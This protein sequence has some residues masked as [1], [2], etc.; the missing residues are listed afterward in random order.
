MSE[1]KQSFDSHVHFRVTKDFMP[2]VHKVARSRGMT[3]S[4]YI[5]AAVYDALE[6]DQI[7]ELHGEEN[8][9]LPPSQTL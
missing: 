8:L 5:R 2:R 6:I 7:R 9:A 1:E 3:A 4:N